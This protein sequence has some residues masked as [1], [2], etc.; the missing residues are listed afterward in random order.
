[1]KS[2]RNFI[3]LDY[4]RDGRSVIFRLMSNK[5]TDKQHLG[6]YWKNDVWLRLFKSKF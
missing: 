1:M 6:G 4:Q 5:S 2:E 3:G